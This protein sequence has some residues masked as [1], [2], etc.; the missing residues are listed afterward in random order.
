MVEGD[1]ADWMGL[2]SGHLKAEG[3]L[4]DLVVG[5]LHYG[6]EW[7]LILRLLCRCVGS[8]A[9]TLREG[10]TKVWV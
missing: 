7:G 4:L 1:G 9:N 8:V 6:M 5:S 10:V 2:Y 3:C